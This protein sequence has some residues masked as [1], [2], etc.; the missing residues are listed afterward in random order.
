MVYWPDLPFYSQASA[1]YG[2]IAGNLAKVIVP[3]KKITRSKIKKSSAIRVLL[4]ATLVL[5]INFWA[6]ALLSPLGSNYA[7]SLHL[8]SFQLSILLAAP[9]I[10]GS[11]GRIIV[12]RLTDK[13]GGRIMLTLLS[14]L[15]ATAVFML[16]GANTYNGLLA[17]ALML[18][19]GGTVF[20][21]G[22]PF[23]SS[24]FAPKNRGLALGIYSIG[25]A[26]TGVAGFVMPALVTNF[27]RSGA[28]VITAICLILVGLISLFWGKN[29]PAWKPI[30]RVSDG[31]G[32]IAA[33]KLKLTWDLSAVYAITFGAFVAF[34]VYLP[35]LLKVAYGLS[36]TDAAARAGGFILVATIARPLG[37]WIS[38][39]LGAKRI[40]TLMLGLVVPL[41]TFAAVQSSLTVRATGTYLTLAFVLGAGSGA[42]FALVG[43]L[44]KPTMVGSM[45]G[46][47]G[48]IGGLGGFLPPIVLGLTYQHFNSYAPAFWL[49]ALTSLLVWF[50]IIR[51]FRDHSV[52]SRANGML[53]PE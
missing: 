29:S 28:F 11:L 41:A 26:G 38:D 36:L 23:V 50:Y 31:S 48:A 51:R 34:G 5:T 3:N 7:D 15:T 21:V 25:D 13:F 30:K 8:S 53:G 24:W 44:A 16:I 46:I 45:S 27:N 22:V 18:G 40:V 9:V 4:I 2:T 47:V 6:W 42:V 19:L 49:L 32:I 33:L 14:F 37:G 43:R 12:G 39:K 10:I 35:V 20:V 17:V 52:Y 1:F